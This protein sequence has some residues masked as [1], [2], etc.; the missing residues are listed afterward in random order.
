MN[1]INR[2]RRR[3][4]LIFGLNELQGWKGDYVTWED[5]RAVCGGYDEAS[6]LEKIKNAVLKVK[7]GEA[8]YER[9]SVVFSEI[10]FVAPVLEKFQEIA[11]NNR[12]ALNVL[13]FGGSLGSSY[14]QYKGL[15]NGVSRLNW[16]VV[17]QAHYV[18]CGKAN[19]EDDSLHFYYH[20]SEVLKEMQPDVILLSSVIQYFPNPY[21]ML[22]ELMELSVPNIIL[23]RTAFM[24]NGKQR[25]TLQYV[26]K[27][28][29]KASYP[30]WFL[31]ES[32]F[33]NFLT[34]KYELISSHE[35]EISLP[36]KIDGMADVHWKGHILKLR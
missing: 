28:I 31:N 20:Y 27:S 8:A 18:D 13:D 1:I 4:R 24:V 6:I 14:F 32:E 22:E 5:A 17:E 7:N 9:D 12:G 11:D 29:Y 10:Q 25:L 16:C 34:R 19:F 33:V 30:A 2:I 23:D 35:S 3:I 26:P 36:E 15:L 21:A